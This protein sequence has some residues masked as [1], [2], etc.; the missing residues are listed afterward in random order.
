MGIVKLYRKGNGQGGDYRA[1][2]NSCSYHEFQR[3]IEYKAT[4]EGL[5]VIYVAASG[6]SVKRAIRGTKTFPNVDRTLLC[7]NCRMTFDRDENAARNTLAKGALRFGADGLLVEAVKGNP[8]TPVAILRVDGGKS[9]SE[10][11]HAP[12]S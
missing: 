2:L 5:P 8:K 12:P 4:R 9:N 7:P 6:T 1:K 11:E 3:Q 10:G